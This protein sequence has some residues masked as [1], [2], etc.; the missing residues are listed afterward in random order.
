MKVI[1][2]RGDRGE[3]ATFHPKRPGGCGY[4]NIQQSQS[5]D[6]NSL[7]HADLRHLLDNHGFLEVT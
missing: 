5:S 7:T 1:G 2:F 6:Q 4:H 3:M